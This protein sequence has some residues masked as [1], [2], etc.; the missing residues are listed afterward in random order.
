M[1]CTP[2]RDAT[3]LLAMKS[4]LAEQAANLR[5]ALDLFSVGIEMH[6]LTLRRRLPTAD[7]EEIQAQI[8]RWLHGPKLVNSDGERGL[9][10][11][12]LPQ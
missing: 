4:N 6:R 2:W 5:M 9:R 12:E 1:P 11:R 8:A 7:E 3:I 10:L